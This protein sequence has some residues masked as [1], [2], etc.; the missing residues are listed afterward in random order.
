[1][2]MKR[3][4]RTVLA[5]VVVALS[6]ASAAWGEVNV[7]VSIGI[8]MPRIVLPA[9]PD[10]ILS[11]SL[12]FYVAVGIPHDIYRVNRN[13]YLFQNDRWYR[14]TY[15]NG[16]WRAMNHNQLP[17]SLRRYNHDKIRAVRDEEYRH[18]QDNRDRY[19][20][21]HFKPSKSWKEPRA[22]RGSSRASQD[23]RRGDRDGGKQKG[24]GH[25]K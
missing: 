18:Y 24:Q 15:Y 6:L 17:R 8:P 16:P 9:P 19:R 23:N 1:M 25:G 5:V 12:G 2:V 14:G 11:P 3:F 21:K 20:G 10:F 22:D 7:G 4:F 13:Y